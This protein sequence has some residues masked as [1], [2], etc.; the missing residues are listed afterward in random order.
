MASKEHKLYT[1]YRIVTL[2]A[3]QGPSYHTNVE[4]EQVLEKDLTQE[5]ALELALSKRMSLP[6]IKLVLREQT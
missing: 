2:T 4:V 1:L 5:K 6:S 3:Y